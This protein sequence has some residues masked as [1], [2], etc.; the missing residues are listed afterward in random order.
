MDEEEGTT[1][2]AKGA[3]REAKLLFKDESYKIVGGCFKV[4]KEKRSGFPWRPCTRNVWALKN[5]DVVARYSS[6]VLRRLS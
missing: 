1:K 3:K 5:L 2:Y 6:K 4:Y